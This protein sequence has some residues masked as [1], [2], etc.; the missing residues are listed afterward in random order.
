MSAT[1][2][3]APGELV[4]KTGRKLI[5]KAEYNI[6]AFLAKLFEQPFWFFEEQRSRLMDHLDNERGERK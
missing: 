2:E 5:T 1:R 3:K 6:I 4:S